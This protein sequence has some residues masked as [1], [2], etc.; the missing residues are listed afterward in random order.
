MF[1]FDQLFSYRGV[2][3]QNGGGGGEANQSSGA[4]VGSTEKHDLL[5]RGL[6]RSRLLHWPAGGALTLSLD[7]TAEPLGA[8]RQALQFYAAAKGRGAG[9]CSS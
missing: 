4:G 3:L 8:A 2:L 5:R 7:Q 9:E 6:T 1:S